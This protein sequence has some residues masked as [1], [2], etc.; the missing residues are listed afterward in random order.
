MFA[1]LRCAGGQGFP[2]GVAK[3]SIFVFFSSSSPRSHTRCRHITLPSHIP[4]AES[5]RSAQSLR[6]C[7]HQHI[8]GGGARRHTWE[9]LPLPGFSLWKQ[10]VA[11]QKAA[12]VS[13]SVV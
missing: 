2:T 5:R 11:V 10:L 7:A 13:E 6:A 9:R 12:A 1:L 8:P 4:I 3:R